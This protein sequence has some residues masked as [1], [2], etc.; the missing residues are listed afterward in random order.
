MKKPKH[1]I[2]REKNKPR[3]RSIFEMKLDVDMQ[4]PMAEPILSEPIPE[5]IVSEGIDYSAPTYTFKNDDDEDQPKEADVEHSMECL[6]K[7][8]LTEKVS[9]AQPYSGSYT[10]TNTS[11]TSF[12]FST[13]DD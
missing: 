7:E 6:A 13:N 1:F 5:E 4:E 8:I 3:R 10:V 2:Q 9:E 12:T 11:F